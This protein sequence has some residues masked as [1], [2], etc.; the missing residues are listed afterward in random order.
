MTK[1]LEAVIVLL[2][3]VTAQ[4]ARVEARP[5]RHEGDSLMH[6]EKEMRRHFGALCELTD[7]L[8]RHSGEGN[9]P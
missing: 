6:L 5:D 9:S 4:L 7:M 1:E 8:L 2:D 3:A